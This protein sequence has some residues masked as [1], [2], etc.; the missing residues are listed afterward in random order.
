[1]K[2]Q[3]RGRHLR[4]LKPPRGL[5]KGAVRGNGCG[6]GYKTRIRSHLRIFV[7]WGFVANRVRMRIIGGTDEV[8]LV[9]LL[10]C[11]IRSNV[12]SNE[13]IRRVIFLNR[14]FEIESVC[15]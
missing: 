3:R 7:L 2:R 1:M 5:R 15:G 8:G 14:M 13:R 4:A 12:D 9:Y 10:I 6:I 11:Y